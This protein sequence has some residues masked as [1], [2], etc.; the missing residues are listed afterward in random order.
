MAESTVPSVYANHLRLAISFTD[1]RLYCGELIPEDSGGPVGQTTPTGGKGVDRVCIVL[2][3]DII[4][5]LINGLMNA[6]KTYQAQFGQLR[7]PPSLP[8]STPPPQPEKQ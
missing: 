1:F 4:P 2:S 7:K 3:P 5:V 8:E 6:V